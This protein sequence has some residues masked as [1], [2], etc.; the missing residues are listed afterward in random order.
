MGAEQYLAAPWEWEQST[1]G[2]DQFLAAGS[3]AELVADQLGIGAVSC[4]S[5]EVREYCYEILL[6]SK[7]APH[8]LPW[9]TKI[10]L[11]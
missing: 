1:F 5:M 9:S 3:G 2:V 4:Y 8:P 11:G 6:R 10:L 7:S